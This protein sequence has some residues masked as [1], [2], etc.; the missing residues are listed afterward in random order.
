MRY[1][2]A[3]KI[4]NKYNCRAQLREMKELDVHP[5][6]RYFIALL[7]QIDCNRWLH[8]QAVEMRRHCRQHKMK[9][10]KR[11]CSMKLAARHPELAEVLGIKVGNPPLAE[12]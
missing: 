12:R 4:L 6:R 3:K 5:V 7:P 9:L 2:Q 1:R 11:R 8:A 10:L